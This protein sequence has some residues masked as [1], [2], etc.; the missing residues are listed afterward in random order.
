MMLLIPA[1][2]F[3][4]FYFDTQYLQTYLHFTP[5]RTGFAFLPLSAPLFA[6]ARLAPRAIGHFGAKRTAT[7]GVLIN[8]AGI[9]WM[10]QLSAS[11][12]YVAGLLGPLMLVGLGVGFTMMPLTT[13]VLGGVAPKEAG[14][15]AGL[16]QTMQQIG[17]SLGLSILVTIF[18]TVSRHAHDDAF[19]HGATAA[20][21]MA[22]V[23]TALG[24]VLALS[25]KPRKPAIG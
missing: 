7:A 23:F 2:M 16:L 4:V 19:I 10:S 12:G 22:A 6:G 18:G 3:G 17:G 21:T 1:G 11:D 8:L 14:S 20:F 13:F 15:A 25:L 24:L 5:L 9:S